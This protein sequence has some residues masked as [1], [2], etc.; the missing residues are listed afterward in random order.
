[1]LAARAKGSGRYL[2]KL[3]SNI[4]ELRFSNKWLSG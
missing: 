1:M 4:A 3:Y 2:Y